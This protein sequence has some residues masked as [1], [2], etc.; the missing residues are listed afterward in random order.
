MPLR[1]AGEHFGQPSLQGSEG[2]ER[3]VVAFGKDAHGCTRVHAVHTDIENDIVALPKGIHPV[4]LAVNGHL[5]VAVQNVPG[6]WIPEDVGAGQPMDLLGHKSTKWHG[7]HHAVLVVPD[8]DRRR[9]CFRH[10][11]CPVDTTHAV[12]SG[13]S[14]PNEHACQ[15]VV[16]VGNLDRWM[17]NGPC[18]HVLSGVGHRPIARLQECVP[19]PFRFACRSALPRGVGA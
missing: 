3:I 4:S 2:R 7:I 16:Q 12:V 5:V 10:V 19:W 17:K 14:T 6:H 11:V 8:E 9:S 15:T 18:L 13:E 1:G